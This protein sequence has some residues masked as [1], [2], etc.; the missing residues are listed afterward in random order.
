MGR[1]APAVRQQQFEQ[2]HCLEFTASVQTLASMYGCTL[3]RGDTSLD[4]GSGRQSQSA[5]T[6]GLSPTVVCRKPSPTW[7]VMDWARAR[8]QRWTPGDG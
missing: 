7:T 5:A 6:V 4:P 1:E 2:I 8:G 3:Q